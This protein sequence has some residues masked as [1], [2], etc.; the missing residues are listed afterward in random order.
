VTHK[1][2]TTKSSIGQ[3]NLKERIKSAP[4][5]RA[6]YGMAMA[7]TRKC[8]CRHKSSDPR[9]NPPAAIKIAIRTP[10]IRLE[11]RH[12]LGPAAAAKPG[13]GA[14]SVR[15]DGARAIRLSKARRACVGLIADPGAQQI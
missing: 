14:V 4:W 6:K 13:I 3:H 11:V 7:A 1:P 15:T 9:E 2:S 5:P 10:D 12:V 8:T